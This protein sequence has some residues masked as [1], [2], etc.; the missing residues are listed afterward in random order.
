MPRWSAYFSARPHERIMNIA[1]AAD[2][3]VSALES[4][5]VQLVLVECRG[6]DRDPVHVVPR[7]SHGVVR[8]PV[9]FPD[10]CW[11]VLY[12]V[13]LQEGSPCCRTVHAT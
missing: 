1:I 12:T 3:R 7:A 6:G 10:S 13:D 2:A 8:F 4:F 5:F 11:E 9:S